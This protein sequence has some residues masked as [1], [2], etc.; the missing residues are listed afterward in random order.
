MHLLDI[1]S[2]AAV[3]ASASLFLVGVYAL[4]SVVSAVLWWLVSFVA[5]LL[6]FGISRCTGGRGAPADWRS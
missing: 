3:L 2:F 5:S 4:L 1:H 6:G